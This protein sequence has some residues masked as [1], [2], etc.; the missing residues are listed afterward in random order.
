ML[1]KENMGLRAELAQARRDLTLAKSELNSTKKL[2]NECSHSL[3]IERSLRVHLE[4]VLSKS[5]FPPAP[6]LIIGSSIIPDLNADLYVNMETP[7]KTELIQMTSE[8]SSR[9]RCIREYSTVESL[10]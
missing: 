10:S 6:D 7:A 9:K 8:N 2:L 5:K 1:Q 3:V 4:T